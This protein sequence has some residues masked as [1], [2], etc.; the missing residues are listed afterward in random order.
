LVV[1]LGRFA[2]APWVTMVG[3]VDAIFVSW[4]TCGFKLRWKHPCVCNPSKV[5]VKAANHY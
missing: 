1:N 5:R 3:L 2:P 4:L